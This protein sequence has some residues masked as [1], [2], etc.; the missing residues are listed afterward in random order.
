M[1]TTTVAVTVETWRKLHALKKGPSD[2][3]GAV[4]ERLAD[5]EICIAREGIPA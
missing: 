5:R 3:L 4:I 2:S 1:Q